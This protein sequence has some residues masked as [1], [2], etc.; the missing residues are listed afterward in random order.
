[1]VISLI[2]I[3]AEW[4]GSRVCT[5]NLALFLLSPVFISNVTVWFHSGVFCVVCQQYHLVRFRCIKFHIRYALL[6]FEPKIY[7]KK[8]YN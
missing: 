5:Q 7:K 2:I 4:V 8:C 1:M 3:L 6:M